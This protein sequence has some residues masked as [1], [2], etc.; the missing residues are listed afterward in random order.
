MGESDHSITKVT[1]FWKEHGGQIIKL[2]PAKKTSLWL[3][4]WAS[5]P[6]RVL[7]FGGKG[8]KYLPSMS[9]SKNCDFSMLHVVFRGGP[10]NVH[11]CLWRGEG[12]GSNFLKKWLRGL[13]S[14][15]NWGPG[16]IPDHWLK[17][18]SVLFFM[19]STSENFKIQNIFKL[20]QK[21]YYYFRKK[22][23]SSAS[24]IFIIFMIHSLD[25]S[26]F[27]VKDCLL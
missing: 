4:D 10:G 15:H 21:N 1:V 19:N 2:F 16:R 3:A 17:I 25:L 5:W 18:L 8:L 20:K 11:V 13:C 22:K 9:F 27:Q 24:Y 23:P 7:V 12:G 14:P 6:I 26:H